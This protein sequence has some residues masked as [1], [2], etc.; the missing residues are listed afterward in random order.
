LPHERLNY[1]VV[2]LASV[3][4]LSLLTP[5]LVWAAGSQGDIIQ[6]DTVGMSMVTRDFTTRET[7]SVA[8]ASNV[9][10]FIGLHCYIA[11]RWRLGMNVQFTERLVPAPPANESR[12]RSYAF[13]PQI[14]YNF[15]DPFFA[16]IVYKIAPRTNGQSNLDMAIQ[17]VLGV[18]LPLSPRVRMTF[19]AEAP[20]AFYIHRTLGL[21]L[22][23]GISIRL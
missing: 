13:N 8:D 9:S 17:G 5:D 3:V 7:M 19:A 23:A 4:G 21:T 20:F 6:T 15:Y 14:G 2:S 11:D 18:G 12:F 1:Y 10:E 22:L 16:A